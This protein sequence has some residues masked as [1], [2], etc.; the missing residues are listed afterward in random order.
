MAARD[1]GGG[2]QLSE[3]VR[4]QLHDAG[5]GDDGQPDGAE[6]IGD[7]EDAPSSGSEEEE[8]IAL[9]GKSDAR[10]LDP[11]IKEKEDG[12]KSME[13][14][15]NIEENKRNENRQRIVEASQKAA[16]ENQELC[17]LPQKEQEEQISG[18][19]LEAN[20]LSRGISGLYCLLV[21]PFSIFTTIS[22]ESLVSISVCWFV[23]LDEEDCSLYR[24]SGEA[25]RLTIH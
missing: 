19:V 12:R 1:D 20:L 22:L 6:D 11:I 15:R 17:K 13:Q 16:R 18:G 7:Y 4:V 14:L 24:L 9:L 3:D 2:E 23:C 21:I 25:T 8:N 5:G 10:D